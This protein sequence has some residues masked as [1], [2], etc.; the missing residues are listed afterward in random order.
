MFL[1][2]KIAQNF[3]IFTH[4]LREFSPGELIWTW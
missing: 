1:Y 2:D 3:F 4:I